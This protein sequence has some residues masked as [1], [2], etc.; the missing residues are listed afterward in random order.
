MSRGMIGLLL[1]VVVLGAV[2]GIAEGPRALV[3]YA[4]L[5]GIPAAIGIGLWVGG[6]WLRDSSA[7][8]FDRRR[9]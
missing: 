6:D 9:R 7:G 4:F 3:V 2:I 5:A 1:A 8:R